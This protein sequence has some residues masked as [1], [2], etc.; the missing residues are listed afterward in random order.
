MNKNENEKELNIDF[1]GLDK[2]NPSKLS[3]SKM[4]LWNYFLEVV[5]QDSFRDS[6]LEVRNKCEV[7]IYSHKMKDRSLY[8]II[9]EFMLINEISK[10]CDKYK[11][12]GNEFHRIVRDIV[13]DREVNVRSVRDSE[14]LPMYMQDDPAGTFGEF[15]QCTLRDLLNENKVLD[16]AFYLKQVNERWPIAI[17]ISPYVGQKELK[18]FI[19]KNWKYIKVIQ[20]KRK[21]S[22]VKIGKYRTKN[23]KSKKIIE[24][25]YK[26]RTM[27]REKLAEEV[28]KK[29]DT[30]YGYAEIN[31]I[32]TRESKRRKKISI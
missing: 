26:N 18:D 8:D 11:L 31:S 4:K 5:D 28:N 20:D 6:I 19:D 22:N 15:D 23:V 25:A 16:K 9:D 3:L 27:N 7:Q 10:L 13:I 1:V 14:L 21:D 30:E 32:I 12:K 2:F 17:C 29:F 24:F